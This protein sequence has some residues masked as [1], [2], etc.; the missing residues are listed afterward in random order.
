MTS[1]RWNRIDDQRCLLHTGSDWLDGLAVYIAN[2]GVEFEI[3][4]PP[5]L[6]DRVAD[7]AARFARATDAAHLAAGVPGSEDAASG[8]R[9]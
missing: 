3:V 5:E 9:P 1:A 7:L 6:I 8:L 2:I 4:E